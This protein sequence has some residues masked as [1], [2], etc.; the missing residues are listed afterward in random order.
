MVSA[1]KGIKMLFGRRQLLG[2]RVLRCQGL[3]QKL[4]SLLLQMLRLEVKVEKL[5]RK[6]IR[7]RGLLMSPPPLLQH[8]RPLLSQKILQV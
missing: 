1:D 5:L 3:L 7:V 6:Q 2:Q 8:R 4:V